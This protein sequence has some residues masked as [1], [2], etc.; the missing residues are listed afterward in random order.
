MMLNVDMAGP[1]SAVFATSVLPHI[2][3]LAALHAGL[4]KPKFIG[5]VI[6]LPGL[7]GLV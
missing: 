6:A 4:P 2:E 5:R 3:R 1:K 7:S